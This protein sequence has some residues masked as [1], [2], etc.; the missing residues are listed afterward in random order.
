MRLFACLH[1]ERGTHESSATIRIAIAVPS[2]SFRVGNAVVHKR[3][4]WRGAHSGHDSADS[5]CVR[6]DWSRQFGG[7]RPPRKGLNSVTG[8]QAHRL[9]A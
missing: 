9:R 5:I 8:T 7:S 2:G 3:C 6:I 1:P 4:G